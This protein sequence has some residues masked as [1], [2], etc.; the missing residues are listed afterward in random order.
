MKPPIIIDVMRGNLVESTHQA[1]AVVVDSD[2]KIIL[3]YGDPEYITCFRSSL[4]PFQAAVSVKK[5]YTDL[6][7]FNSEEIALMCASHNGE[8][9]HTD[10]VESMLMKLGVN[11]KKL[12][13]GAH[14]SYEEKTKIKMIKE[15]VVH[16]AI[17]NN[18][19]GKHAGMLCL[20]KGLEVDFNNYINEQHLVQKTILDYIKNLAE[21]SFIGLGIDGCSVPTPF[22]KLKII[23]KMY[24]KLALGSK[25]ELKKLFYCMSENPYIIAG[26]DRFDT[27]F[28]KIMMGRAISKGGGEAIQ[29]IALNSKKYGP[30]GV[31]LK[32]LDGSHRVRDVANIHVLNSLQELTN[33]EREGMLHYEEKTIMNHNSLL[34]GTIKIRT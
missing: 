30:I 7:K 13:C 12:E 28:T 5:G 18:C 17:H 19:S 11:S 25:K 29:G 1:Y 10:I 15:G 23:A 20:A 4:K 2:N 34:T 21:T 16:K 27:V 26:K 6:A 33:K 31:S 24:M 8:K 9:I 22:F 3:S 32:V 14:E